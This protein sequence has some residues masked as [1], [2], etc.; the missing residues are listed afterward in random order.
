MERHS[1]CLVIGAGRIGLPLSVSLARSGIDVTILERDGNKVSL[2]NEGLAPFYEV[3]M[4]ESSAVAVK[5]GK[6]LA[7]LELNEDDKYQTVISAIGTGLNNDGTPD[8]SAL[9]SLLDVVIPNISKFGLLILKTTLPIGMTRMIANKLYEKTK[10]TLDE[11]LFVVFSPERIVEGKAMEELRT[12]PKIIGGIGPKSAIKAN[13]ILKNLGGEIIIV[14]DSETAEMCKLLDNSYRMT[15]FGFAADVAA[16]AVENGIDAY[17]AIKAAN[18]GYERNNIPLPSVGVSGY[19][20]TKDPYYLDSSAPDVW[21]NRGFPST[22]N[23]ARRA[24]DFQTTYAFNRIIEY[25]EGSIEGKRIVIGGITYKENIDDT[26]LSHGRE[27]IAMFKKQKADLIIWDNVTSDNIV[28]GINVKKTSKALEGADCLLITVPHDEYIEWNIKKK[29][30]SR[31]KNKIIFDGWGIIDN[32][33][34]E[35]LVLFGTGMGK[36]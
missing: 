15:R 16:V 9:E 23:T 21:K 10:Y 18:K 31:M 6:I 24:A 19:C 22:W 17:E 36:K 35:D 2:I 8:L 27:L 13:Q 7:T 5:N 26:R 33:N 1:R 12:L 3:E 29:N 20:L 25:F 28:D 4:D 34:I 14:S 30:I 32:S 11:E